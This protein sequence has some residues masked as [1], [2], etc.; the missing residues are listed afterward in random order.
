MLFFISPKH[1]VDIRKECSKM[2]QK[3]VLFSDFFTA[4]RSNGKDPNILNTKKS[5]S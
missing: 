2:N 3:N 5:D 4:P 1:Q